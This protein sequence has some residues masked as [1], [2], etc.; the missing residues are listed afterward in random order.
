MGDLNAKVVAIL[1]IF[2]ITW[3]LHSFQWFWLR[4]TFP[5]RTV[6]AIFWGSFG[7]LVAGNAVLES[8]GK[9]VRERT[10]GWKY[11]AIM[12]SKIMG[13][14]LTMSILWSIWSAPTWSYWLEIAAFGFRPDL[15]S[16][17]VLLLIAA[18]LWGTGTL[19]YYLFTK[20]NWGEIVN[21]DPKSSLASGWS[22]GIVVFLLALH[23]QPVQKA[24][25]QFASV[26]LDG[27]LEHRLNEADEDLLVE[28]YYEEILIGNE[29]TSP[30]AEMMENAEGRRFRD[31]DGA[32]IVDD[33]R[34]VIKKESQSFLFKGQEFSTNSFGIR[35]REYPLEKGENTIRS[36]V[37]GGSY[38]VGS[39]VNNQ[40]VFD[41]RLEQE[42]NSSEDSLDFEFWNFGS[43]G[44]D[45]IQSIYDFEVREAARHNFDNLIYI[46]HGLDRQKNIQSLSQY[47]SSGRK[48]PYPFLTDIFN[49]IGITDSMSESEIL[50]ALKPVGNEIIRQSYKYLY[51]LCLENDIKP[52]WVYW[53]TT[54]DRENNI[55]LAKEVQVMVREIGFAVIDLE[56]VYEGVDR[57]EL[58]VSSEK[59]VDAHPNELGHRLIS[60]ALYSIFMDDPNLLYSKINR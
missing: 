45:L 18:G 24:A 49:K 40:N 43:S 48:S 55:E 50:R 31:S 8:K 12:M 34:N 5:L 56:S 58:V 17:G 41:H 46:S 2:V 3:F 59:P 14:F 44:F 29:L 52:I 37:L 15:S 4:G 10:R 33:I 9:K 36:A 20:N 60:E 6:D 42:M 16:Y 53:P 57:G 19:L 23:V 51:E 28:G 39:G 32:L 21:P 54:R 25:S 38:V 30:L 22:A 13:M 35:D 27:L 47:L 7:L 1:I 11:S 26:N